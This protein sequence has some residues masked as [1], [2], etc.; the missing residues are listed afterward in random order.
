MKKS[1][2]HIFLIFCVCFSF[3]GYAD[4]TAIDHAKISCEYGIPEPF[5]MELVDALDSQSR[6]SSDQLAAKLILGQCQ[7]EIDKGNK[8]LMIRKGKI[9]FFE[10]SNSYNVEDPLYFC[11]NKTGYN[12]YL[13]TLSQKFRLFSREK[14]RILREEKYRA[15]RENP[16]N[17]SKEKMIINKYT[18]TPAPMVQLWD[19]KIPNYIG[20]IRRVDIKQKEMLALTYGEE[21]CTKVD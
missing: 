7:A 15:I 14:E 18:S 4:S 5:V 1:L 20:V 10:F 3:I 16:E 17:R 19:C 9:R 12:V 2:N 11:K 13:S 21:S 8:D 6:F